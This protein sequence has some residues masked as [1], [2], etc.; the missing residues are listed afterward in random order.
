M[1]RVFSPVARITFALLGITLALVLAAHA[2]RI[3]PDAQTEALA[4]RKR[5]VEA[6][7]VQLTS[8][9]LL[10]DLDDTAVVLDS[11]VERSPEIL[12]AALRDANGNIVLESGSHEAFWKKTS[13]GR[14]TPEFVRAPIYSGDAEI[15]ALE[16]R[17]E[18]LP[19]PWALSFNHGGVMSLLIFVT[20]GGALGYFLVLRRSLRAL[21]PSAVVPERVKVAM[22]TLVEGVIIMDER[23]Q[24]L[25][26]NQ[27]FGRYLD[28]PVDQLIGKRASALNWKSADTGGSAPE[29]PWVAAMA[30]RTPVTDCMLELRAA[31]QAIRTFAVNATPV[32]DARG[33][34]RGALAS[35]DDVTELRQQNGELQRTLTQLE[36]SRQVVEK[37]NAELRYLAS[38]DPLT[39]CLNRR[40]FFDA[41]G[42]AFESAVA[43]K[44]VLCCAMIDIDHF[45]GVNDRFG[46]ATGDRVI[47]FVAETVRRLVSEADLVGRYGGEEYCVVFVSRTCFE[48]TVVLDRIR[49]A[50][51]HGAPARFGSKLKVTVSA[52]VTQLL[53]GDVNPSALLA[54]ADGALYSAKAEGRDRVVL[55]TPELDTAAAERQLRAAQT[56]PSVPRQAGRDLGQETGLFRALTTAAGPRGPLGVF[57]DGVTQALTLAA[58]HGWTMALLRI[59]LETAGALGAR[60]QREILER[61]SALLRGSDVLASLLGEHAAKSEAGAL[62]SASPLGPSELGVLLPHVSDV[63]AIG[64]AVQ[65]VI[66]A[67]GEPLIVDNQET[68]VGCAIGISVA[69]ADGNDV[70]TLMHRAEHARRI[71]L[72]ARGGERYA[73]YQSSMTETLVSAMRVE[74]GLRRA[75]ERG[76]FTLLYQP[77]V[78]LASG[79]MRGFEAL[80]RWTD[81]LGL[82]MEPQKFIP[83]AESCGLIVPIGEWVLEKACR[84]AHDWQLVGGVVH[85]VAVNISPVQITSPGFA[86]RV[87]AI[88]RSTHVDPRLIDLEITETA[89]MSDLAAAAATLRQLRRLGLHISLDDFGTG[90]SSLSYLKQLPIDSLKIDSRFVKDLRETREGAALVAAIVGM[91]HGLGIRVV[92]EGVETVDALNMLKELGCDEAQG[93]LISPAVGA[94]EAFALAGTVFPIG[95]QAADPERRP[96]AAAG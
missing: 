67:I 66:K 37:H 45:K 6:L 89:F 65:R 53:K 94:R 59:E 91:A 30:K 74:N 40:A 68:F 85:R 96:A 71:V 33:G 69:P 87:A 52:G 12:S 26:A 36:E 29:L 63:N 76:E 39:G 60:A 19:S 47:G 14:S 77:Q 7:T 13:D 58:G 24:V 20:V 23:E 54:R 4:N 49:A 1:R 5:T 27:A 92:A 55:W 17:F 21:D 70:D 10:D 42:R 41:F 93:F 57:R 22:D 80:L 83:I 82:A 32:L 44:E 31:N 61:I 86:D 28:V 35:F 84:Q 90:Y 38:H 64:R 46:H 62:P 3:L 25:L 43:Q 50:V 9:T 48:A 81:S 8:G 11:V 34:V 51:S 78:E 79:R 15:G 88:L 72:A 18:P 16:V 56:D 73:F 75:L 2:L 95:E